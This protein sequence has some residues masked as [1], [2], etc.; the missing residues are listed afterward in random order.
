M[1]VLALMGAWV[2]LLVVPGAAPEPEPARGAC[3]VKT[4]EPA[5]YC[6]MEKRK[7]PDGNA[8]NGKCANDGAE[9]KKIEM[10]VK[11]HYL[12]A[13]SKGCCTDDRP[14]PGNCKCQKPLQE[15][16]DTCMALQQ[17]TTCGKSAPH[18]D[19]V[20]HDETKCKDPSKATYKKTCEKSG[21]FPHG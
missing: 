10:C 18:K 17:C 15:E 12:C 14:R 11:K 3:D 5:W 4:T 20:Q 9:V 7:I 16:V 2:A 13:C 1:R 19:L 21:K 8:V 6:P